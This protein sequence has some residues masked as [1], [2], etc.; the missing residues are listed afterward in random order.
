[1]YRVGRMLPTQLRETAL[2]GVAAT[3][4]GKKIARSIFGEQR[5]AENV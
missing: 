5:V 1:M 3:P 4:T 2:G